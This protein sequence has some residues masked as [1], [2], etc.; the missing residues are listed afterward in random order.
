MAVYEFLEGTLDIPAEKRIKIFCDEEV[1]RA[2]IETEIEG[3]GNNPAIKKDDPILIFYAGHGATAKAPSTWSSANGTIQMLAPHDFNPEGDDPEGVFDI[4]L[5]YLLAA[6]AAKKSDNIT[7]ILDCCYSGSATRAG[8]NDSIVRGI[9]LLD[10]TISEDR[11]RGFEPLSG[12]RGS[13][14]ANGFETEGLTSHVLLS[15]CKATQ[16]ARET[17]GHG[18][19][20]SALLDYLRTTNLNEFVYADIPGSLPVLR[21]SSLD[22]ERQDPQCKGAHKSRYL[23]TTATNIRHPIHAS[24]DTPGLY[25]LEAGEVHGFRNGDQFVVYASRNPTAQA[26]M[27]GTVTISRTTAS[28]AECV[29]SGPGGQFKL[30]YAE[31][32]RRVHGH[33]NLALDL[34][35][36]LTA[37]WKKGKELEGRDKFHLMG[38]GWDKVPEGSKPDLVVTISQKRDKFTFGITDEDCRRYGLEWMPRDSRIKIDD[39][40][41][42]RCFLQRSLHFYYHL[43]RSSKTNFTKGTEG[44][45]NVTLQ[46]KKLKPTTGSGYTSSLQQAVEP[47]GDDLNKDGVIK[48]DADDET[49]YTFKITNHT[50]VDLYVSVFYFDMSNLSIHSYYQPGSAGTDTNAEPSVPARGSLVIGYGEGGAPPRKYFLREGQ[51]VDVGFLKLFITTRNVDLSGIAQETPFDPNNRADA[52]WKPVPPD[53]WDTMCFTVVQ[54]QKSK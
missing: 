49:P 44:K 9:K 33:L 25:I 28:T 7:V 6:L 5:H 50:N 40:D 45:Q 42:I 16:K 54:K 14:V 37:I 10:T 17:G 47:F 39:L 3:L 46:C 31:P 4:K 11:L 34:D 20:T 12:D 8:E 43:R 32:A 53:L 36:G 41:T 52:P 23:F 15:A 26:S 29:F 19:F 51:T 21:S 30:G 48:V 27:L 18:H 24:P 1:T 13:G 2:R 22:S 35:E 38:C